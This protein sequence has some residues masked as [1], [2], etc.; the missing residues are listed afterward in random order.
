MLG[1]SRDNITRLSRAIGYLE[2]SG[3]Y[4]EF[5]RDKIEI[6]DN[7]PDIIINDLPPEDNEKERRFKDELKN[8]A[9]RFPSNI[10]YLLVTL[11]KELVGFYYDWLL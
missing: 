7:S 9:A 3:N 1:N 4:R 2:N 6:Q 11:P 5:T 10:P 8:R